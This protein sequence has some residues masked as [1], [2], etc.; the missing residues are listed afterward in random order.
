MD[1][2]RRELGGRSVKAGNLCEICNGTEIE[3]GSCL[4]GA[5][6]WIN[7]SI[8]AAPGPRYTMTI[9]SGANV[10]SYPGGCTVTPNTGGMSCGMSFGAIATTVYS[11]NTISL[12]SGIHCSVYTGKE[13]YGYTQ[14]DANGNICSYINPVET[15]F[16]RNG[17]IGLIVHLE[18]NIARML[19][20]DRL[21]LVQI[22]KLKVIS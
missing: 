1:I 17:I 7:S 11:T 6:N 13:E 3:Q 10:A 20:E 19:I 4:V 16:M 5:G 22:E 14:P 2:A 8:P 21:Y 18:N 12:S 9:A 15:K